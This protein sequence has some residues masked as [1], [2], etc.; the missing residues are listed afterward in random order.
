ME[1]KTR[2]KNKKTFPSWKHVKVGFCEQRT[3]EREEKRAKKT[4]YLRAKL[5]RRRHKR[6]I[7]F[8]RWKV[9]EGTARAVALA[10][11]AAMVLAGYQG[12]NKW[13]LVIACHWERDREV[14]RAAVELREARGL[15]A[16][17]KW[18]IERLSAERKGRRMGIRDDSA[19]GQ[20]GR[21]TQ[22]NARERLSI[23]WSSTSW[24]FY[25]TPQ[26]GSH[27]AARRV[28]TDTSTEVQVSGWSQL[29]GSWVSLVAS[30]CY[31][32]M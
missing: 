22:R 26:T 27:T 9:K 28:E 32:L 19:K 24:S 4:I 8:R 2:T 15:D 7:E 11:Q 3:S 16:K 12:V 14:M 20:E 10:K 17:A 1:L 29:S 23:M 6:Q 31:N 25:V 21:G 13:W 5:T 18:Q 30:S